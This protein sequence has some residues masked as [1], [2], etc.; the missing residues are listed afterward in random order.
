MAMTATLE[1][2]YS[3]EIEKRDRRIAELEA[4]LTLVDQDVRHHHRS[5]CTGHAMIRADAV[6]AVRNALRGATR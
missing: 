2:A 6:I 4:A 3:K 5:G 1:R